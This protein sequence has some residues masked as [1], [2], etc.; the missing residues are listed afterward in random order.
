[1][2]SCLNPREVC[3]RDLGKLFLQR[4]NVEFDIRNIKTTLGMDKFS[5]KHP[6][7]YRNEMLT[8]M[9]SYK[10]I[11]LLMAQAAA[12]AGVLPQQLSFKHTLRVWIAWSQR[13]FLSD[14]PED[15]AAIFRL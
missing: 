6:E 11:R 1:V 10:L 2:T 5:C 9:L 13:Q 4:W 3:K 15:A 12:H 8:Y 7:M 14:A